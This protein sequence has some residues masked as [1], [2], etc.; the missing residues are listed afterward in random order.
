MNWK[1]QKF[2]EALALISMSIRNVVTALKAFYGADPVNLQ[3]TYCE[4]ID[5]YDKPWEYEDHFKMAFNSI[6][7][8][9]YITPFSKE[10][11]LSVYDKPDQTE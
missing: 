6:I 9:S 11:I 7:K 4:N 10:E 8:E 1:P 5:E 2:I 3:F